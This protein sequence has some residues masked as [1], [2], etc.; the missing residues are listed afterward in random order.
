MLIEKGADLRRGGSQDRE[1]EAAKLLQRRSRR[2]GRRVE[3]GDGPAAAVPDRTD[4][5]LRPISISLVTTE[6]SCCRTK[7]SAAR[8]SARSVMVLFVQGVRG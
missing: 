8:S 7:S 6:K 1:K 2:E 4:I 5:D 3:C